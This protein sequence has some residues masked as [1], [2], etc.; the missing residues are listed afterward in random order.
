MDTARKL[1]WLRLG[2]GTVVILV[3][4]LAAWAIGTGPRSLIGGRDELR[5]SINTPP[6][7]PTGQFV[8]AVLGN[9]EDIW[10]EIFAEAGQAYRRPKLRLFSGAEQTPCGDLQR[11][12]VYCPLDERIYLD[13]SIFRDLETRFRA[14]TSDKACEFAEAYLI[15]REVGHHVQNLL[16]HFGQG[17]AAAGVWRP[18]RCRPLAGAGRATS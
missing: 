3:I 10:D 5:A 16:G 4:G 17:T 11:T 14:C 7:D 18:R 9:T 12:M 15:A 13:T 2:I 6:S 1:L 8:A